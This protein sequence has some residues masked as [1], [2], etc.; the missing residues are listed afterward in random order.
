[1]KGPQMIKQ[2]MQNLN[3]EYSNINVYDTSG[4]TLNGYVAAGIYIDGVLCEDASILAEVTR[5]EGEY[6]RLAYSRLRN[7]EY[8]KL[9]QDEMRFDDFIN[10]TTTWS[11][12]ILAIKAQFPKPQEET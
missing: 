6:D 9:N 4:Q 1:M 2:A 3:V 12:A 8:I 7:A 11:D 5:L 10:N